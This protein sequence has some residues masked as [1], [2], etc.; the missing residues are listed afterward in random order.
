MWLRIILLAC[1]LVLTAASCDAER[2]ATVA[3]FPGLTVRELRNNL[4][5][6]SWLKGTCYFEV[7]GRP[8]SVELS[9][10]SSMVDDKPPSS[11]RLVAM[12]LKTIDGQRLALF[13]YTFPDVESCNQCRTVNKIVLFRD[14]GPIIYT[15]SGAN[16]IINDVMIENIGDG[17]E[18]KLILIS[19][20]GVNAWEAQS[21]DVY[22]ISGPEFEVLFSAELSGDTTNSGFEHD[23]RVGVVDWE[24]TRASHGQRLFIRSTIFVEKGKELAVP[25]IE[26]VVYE[27]AVRP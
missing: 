6:T 21:I 17:K 11:R 7:L 8:T 15:Q 1:P 3:S 22:D 5:E 26:T 24:R 12:R 27:R 16:T 2:M 18:N 25:R 19:D 20:F 10:A 14:N 9:A 23:R 13:D 4:P